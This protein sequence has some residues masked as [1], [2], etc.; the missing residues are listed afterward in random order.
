MYAEVNGTRLYYEIE[1]TGTP[2]ML[3]H[4]G[5]GLDHTWFKPWFDALAETA[6]VIYYDHR[7]NGRSERPDTF[8]GVTHETFARDADALREHLGIDRM[9]LFGHSYGGFLAQEYA[10]RFGDRLDG[11]ILCST[12][13]VIDYMDVIQANA[14]D[15]GTSDQLEALAAAFGRPMAD[16]SDYQQVWLTL[17]PLYFKGEPPE[18]WGGDASYSAE[19]WN[20]VSANL[21]P[22]FDIRDALGSVEVPTLILSG[23]DDWITPPAQGG[24]RISE[25]I[26]NSTL[27][28][29]EDSGHYPFIE[30]PQRF[31]EVVTDWLAGLDSD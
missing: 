19:A 27:V 17:L 6:E 10:L 13:P 16:D 4:G 2:L 14:A 8:E 26:P 30:E 20:H 3:M 12:A 5:L 1:G 31:N 21:L 24:E 18:N 11:L 9:V 15:R 23:A 25:A 22:V 29:F 28:V 7:G